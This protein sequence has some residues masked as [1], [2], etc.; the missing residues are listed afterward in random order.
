[1][2]TASTAT[3]T[4]GAITIGDRN[5]SITLFCDGTVNSG[6]ATPITVTAEFQPKGDGTNW[7]AINGATSNSVGVISAAQ[8]TADD[9]IYFVLSDLSWW[10]W[11]NKIRITF[12]AASGTFNVDLIVMTEGS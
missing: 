11:A 9:E 3:A 6:T 8:L 12:T 2:A 10:S 4:S 7:Y 1:M 5:G